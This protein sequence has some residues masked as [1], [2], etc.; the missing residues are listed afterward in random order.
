MNNITSLPKGFVLYSERY[1]YTITKVIGRGANG[2]VYLA[3]LF[4]PK[5][6][7]SC[8][9]ALKEWASQDCCQRL[10]DMSIL[11]PKDLKSEILYRNFMDEY[12][13]LSKINHPN[14]VRVYDCMFTNGT[15]YYSMEF[16]SGG[17][18]ADCIIPSVSINEAL[19]KHIIKQ[20]ASGLD[21]F[22]KNGYIHSDLKLNN[23]AIRNKDIFVLIDGG[24]NNMDSW[25]GEEK[26]NMFLSDICALANILLCLLSGVSEMRPE[27]E[28]A[29]KMFSIAKNKG[30]L[31]DITEKA[32]KL[33]FSAKFR[34]IH[35]FINALEGNIEYG[36]MEE[37][38]SP[39]NE[40]NRMAVDNDPRKAKDFLVKMKRMPDFYISK[41]PVELKEVENIY[42]G[43]SGMYGLQKVDGWFQKMQEGFVLG[44]R[45]PSPKELSQYALHFSIKSGT[46]I[47]Y[48]S[49]QVKFYKAEVTKKMF[50]WEKVDFKLEE[51][52]GYFLP[53]DCKFYFASDL[54]PLITDSHRIHPFAKETQLNYEVI[55]PAS[56]FGFCKVSNRNKWGMVSNRN[57][58]SMA[59]DC[60]YDRIINI[61]YIAIP[62][63]GIPPMFLGIIGYVGEQIDVYELVEGCHLRLKAS[64]TQADWNRRSSYS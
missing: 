23:I 4:S 17:T 52:D 10:E 1:Q 9:V 14:V 53:K 5:H 7:A 57:W 11:Y 20:I 36:L 42:K 33:A 59:I 44:L 32:I 2:Y 35:D 22:H 15:Y 25:V 48:D 46:Y 38:K 49:Q 24:A 27:Y 28:K 62:G 45:L 37:K 8:Q 43:K 55:L 12:T 19:G 6:N 47:T 31:S 50:S 34:Y 63:P 56:I 18:L 54:N 41:F 16:L 39:N 61:A 51:Y 58:V 26:Q 13:A 21:A 40:S 60:K 30:N 29:E 64:M 3:T